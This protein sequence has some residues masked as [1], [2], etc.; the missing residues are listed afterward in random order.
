[1]ASWLCIVALALALSAG[2]ARAEDL[3]TRLEQLQRE[4]AGRP[5]PEPAAVEAPPAAPAA[6]P[7]SARLKEIQTR[8]ARGHR[9]RAAAAA[10]RVAKRA[11][12]PDPA[13]AARNA[14][15]ERER[16][17]YARKAEDVFRPGTEE[18]QAAYDEW[19]ATEPSSAEP[20]PP[21]EGEER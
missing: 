12:S 2:P 13:S 20:P 7:A 16:D 14:A 19:L 10:R 18:Y 8:R 11:E 17:L 3:S 5:A 21:G 6:T 9:E 4:S 15:D 1:M